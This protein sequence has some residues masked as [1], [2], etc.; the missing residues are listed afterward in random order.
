M[1][2]S[3]NVVQKFSS[4]HFPSSLVSTRPIRQNSKQCP[5]IALQTGKLYKCQLEFFI[6]VQYE[7]NIDATLKQY[8]YNIGAM[9]T[10]HLCQSETSLLCQSPF[11]IWCWIPDVSEYIT[12]R[13]FWHFILKIYLKM[14]SFYLLCLYISF[15]EFRDFS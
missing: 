3:A 13:Y 1:R 12:I 2:N 10:Q 5:F 8:G 14:G 4:A 11:L 7:C 6:F 9:W 15:K